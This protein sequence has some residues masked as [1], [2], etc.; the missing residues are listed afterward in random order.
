MNGH[1]RRESD[2]QVVSAETEFVE[3]DRQP[4]HAELP[5][6]VHRLTKAFSAHRSNHAIDNERFE[7]E[8]KEYRQSIEKRIR[9]LE[10]WRV[11]NIA[12][13]A[14]SGAIL[15]FGATI[16]GLLSGILKWNQ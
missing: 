15:A 4:T 10:D 1:R 13:A 8:K 14:T 16:I 7:A 5:G 9:S 3:P 2:F 6:E 12:A 11:Y